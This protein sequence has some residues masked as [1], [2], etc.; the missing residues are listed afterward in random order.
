[1]IEREE[2]SEGAVRETERVKEG[3]KEKA[4]KGAP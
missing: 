1:V 4:G 2:E 3:K